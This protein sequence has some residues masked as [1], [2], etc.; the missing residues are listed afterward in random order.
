VHAVTRKNRRGHHSLWT[1][2]ASDSKQKLVFLI[3]KLVGE[4]VSPTR[5]QILSGTALKQWNK[6]YE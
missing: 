4:R 6:P 3:P 1:A 2:G 5:H